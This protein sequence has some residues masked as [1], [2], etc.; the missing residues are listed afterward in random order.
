[1]QLGGGQMHSRPPGIVD[2]FRCNS[3]N[4]MM[5]ATVTDT[6]FFT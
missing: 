4:A 1:M 3:V 2:A 5:Q 6:L